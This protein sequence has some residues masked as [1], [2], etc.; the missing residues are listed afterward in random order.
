MAKIGPKVQCDFYLSLDYHKIIL[1]IK[2]D[3][4]ITAICMSQCYPQMGEQVD[5]VHSRY[6]ADL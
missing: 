6:D 1:D 2:S 4:Q 3:P 5:T